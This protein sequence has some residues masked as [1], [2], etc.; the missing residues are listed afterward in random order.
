MQKWM[1]SLLAIA[2][3]SSIV[4]GMTLLPPL[5][6]SIINKSFLVGLF[7]LM[8]GCLALVVRSGFFI[9]FL[10]GFKQLKGMFFRK[11]RMMEDDLFQADDPAFQQKKETYARFGTHLLVTIGA[12]LIVFSLVL[13]C[14]Y[15][16]G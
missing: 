4:F 7:V 9:V 5:L 12:S 10:R 6:L 1:T 2:V 14:F 13:T 16:F 8:V 3:I 15:Y 11:P